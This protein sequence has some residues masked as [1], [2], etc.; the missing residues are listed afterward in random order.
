MVS[1][2]LDKTFFRVKSLR[3]DNKQSRLEKMLYRKGKVSG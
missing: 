3:Y 2:N 1:R